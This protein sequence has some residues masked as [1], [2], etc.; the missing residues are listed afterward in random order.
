HRRAEHGRARIDIGDVHEDARPKLPACKRLDVLAQS[1]LVAGAAADVLPRDLVE[2][3]TRERFVLGD[4]Q[5][6]H[7]NNSV[8]LS[9]STRVSRA[10]HAGSRCPGRRGPTTTPPTTGFAR[11][12]A[13]DN[14]AGSPRRASSSMAANTSGRTKSSYGSGRSVILEPAGYG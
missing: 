6:L 5:R 9:R 1:R 12:H 10:F 7:V 2:P 4:V 3:V 13:S 8:S 14:V 11:T